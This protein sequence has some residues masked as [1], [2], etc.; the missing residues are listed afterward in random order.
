M[1]RRTFL[2]LL[3]TLAIAPAATPVARMPGLR[4]RTRHVV[5]LDEVAFVVPS[6]HRQLYQMYLSNPVA[7]HAID[8]HAEFPISS[9]RLP[10]E[11]RRS[12]LG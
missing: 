11:S 1:K 10:S 4:G 8:L 2:A 7:S 5:Y 6:R 9:L 12:A 3:P